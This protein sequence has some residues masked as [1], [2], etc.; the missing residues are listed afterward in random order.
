VFLAALFFLLSLPRNSFEIKKKKKKIQNSFPRSF[1]WASMTMSRHIW[2]KIRRM[3]GGILRFPIVL[4]ERIDP[5]DSSDK[6]F[7]LISNF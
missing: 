6:G 2:K 4:E 3:P 7:D 5:D 1:L